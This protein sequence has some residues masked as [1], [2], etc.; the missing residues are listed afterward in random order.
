LG[1]RMQLN[2]Q[3]PDT[4]PQLLIPAL[5]VQ[6]LLENAIRYGIEN[7]SAP[8]TLHIVSIESRHALTIVITNPYHPNATSSRGNGIALD[9][10]RQRLMLQYG[11]NA[12]LTFGVSEGLYRVKLVIP[13]R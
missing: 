4:L 13:K 8:G 1:N 2:W 6:P 10:I 7:C 3:L 12:S 11:S 5:T 9:N